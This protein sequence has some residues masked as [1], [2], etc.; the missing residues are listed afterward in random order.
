V[1]SDGL[2]L[3]KVWVGCMMPDLQ[4]VAHPLWGRRKGTIEMEEK[5]VADLTGKRISMLIVGVTY[6]AVD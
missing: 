4:V 5:G 2:A 3:W 1:I 6:R